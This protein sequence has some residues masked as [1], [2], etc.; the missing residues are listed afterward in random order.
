MISSP[1]NQNHLNN[2]TMKNKILIFALAGFLLTVLISF[3]LTDTKSRASEYV[4]MRA[5]E[6]I[7]AKS[8]LVISYGN[9]KTERIDLHDLKTENHEFNLDIILGT[10]NRLAA[11]GYTL[12]ST[13]SSGV[14]NKT[15]IVH[16]ETFMFVKN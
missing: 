15:S 3:T 4:M 10:V 11:E 9:G 14:G 13:S 16:V 12:V 1:L 7:G 5:Y 2:L 8:E 6:P